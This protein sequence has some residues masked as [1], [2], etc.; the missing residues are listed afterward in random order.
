M[1]KNYTHIPN[2]I[3][4]GLARL[5]ISGTTFN[6]LFAIIRY[7][8]SF[9]RNQHELSNG[10]LMNATGLNERA[11]I[12]AIQ[13]LQDLKI[14]KIVSKNNGSHPR[15][16]RILTDK[17]VTLTKTQG[18]TDKNVSINTDKNVSEN[19]D[20]IVSQEI[21]EEIKNQI[22]EKERKPSFSSLEEMSRYYA[23][24]PEEGGDDGDI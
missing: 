22:K 15:T 10:F 4:A 5:R 9:H 14:I 7:T 2:D 24:H 12:R 19:T 13:E 11:V 18:G 23:E 8:I 20:K 21:K 3:L 16:I 1:A 6:V 17:I